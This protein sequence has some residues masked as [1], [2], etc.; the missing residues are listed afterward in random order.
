MSLKCSLITSTAQAPKAAHQ[1]D[2]GYDIYSDEECVIPSNSK[3]L[4]STGIRM[5]IP[6]GYYGRIAPRSSLA[7]KHFI[8][9]GGG[10]IDSSYRGEIKVLLFNHGQEEF[11]VER[12]MRIAQI[13]IEKCFHGPILLCDELGSTER[14]EGGFGSTGV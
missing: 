8:G 9:I 10:V 2:A 7:Y 11:R 6:L 3:Y 1:H 14:D 12:G 13:I 5:A 4:V